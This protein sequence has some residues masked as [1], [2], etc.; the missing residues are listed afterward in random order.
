MNESALH[1]VAHVLSPVPMRH[2]KGS[3]GCGEIHGLL[4]VVGYRGTVS[5]GGR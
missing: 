3:G 1:A 4:L 5:A 2:L